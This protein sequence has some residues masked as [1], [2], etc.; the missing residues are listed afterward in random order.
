[1]KK[2]FLITLGILAAAA[3][4]IGACASGTGASGRAGG[5]AAG[6]DWDGEYDVI[7]AGYGGAGATAAVTAADAGA[8]V[9]LLEKAPLGHEGGNTRYALQL[10]MVPKEGQRENAITYYKAMR[11]DYN[12]QTDEMIEYIVDGAMAN[13]DWLINMG[14]PQ[15]NLKP[16]PLIEYPELPGGNEAI[17]TLYI[18]PLR[19]NATLYKFLHSL[20]DAR[21]DKIDV[22]FESPAVRLIQDPATKIVHGVVVEREGRTYNI[23]ARNGV[24]LATG[25]FENNDIMLENYAQLGNAYS[26]AA[27]YNTGDGITMAQEAGAD[28]WHM[29]TLAGPDVNFINP[30]S[31]I[32]QNYYFTTGS[33]A[34]NFTG[35]GSTSMIIVGGNGQRFMNETEAP[36]HGHVEVGGT[37]FS[38]LV[39]RNSWCLFDEAARLANR[40]Y[41]EWSPGCEEEI[42]KGWVKRAANLQEL[43]QITGID[44]AGLQAEIAKYNG[45]CRAGNDPE[46]G[47]NPQYLRPIAT[48]GPY[49]AFPVH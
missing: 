48:Q 26:K 43:A 45:Y 33:P 38:L 7:V 18:D 47:V 9:L 49:Y 6:I 17:T 40:P 29:S 32:A 21:L 37:W 15:A 12:N 13:K 36:R 23:R 16:F 1:M 30:Q 28:L 24:V 25:G 31:G 5:F 41:K 20:V 10:V 14:V 44:L 34:L 19:W 3:A 42:A 8:R 11:G 35:F 46:Y 39:P 22:W 2:S 4:L 27:R